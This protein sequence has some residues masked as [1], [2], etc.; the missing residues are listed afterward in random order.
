MGDAW[1]GKMERILWSWVCSGGVHE[2]VVQRIDMIGH[3]FLKISLF[4]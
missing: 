1:P 2:Q 4:R 3:T